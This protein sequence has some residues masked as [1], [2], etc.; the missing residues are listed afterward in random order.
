ML[1]PSTSSILKNY[2]VLQ[3]TLGEVQDG[4]DEYMYA[5]KA[6]GLFSKL[7]QFEAYSDYSWPMFHLSLLSSFPLMSRL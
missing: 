5:A 2:K 1:H 3:T 7:E 4:H 6:S